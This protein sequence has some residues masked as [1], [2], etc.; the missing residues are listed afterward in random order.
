MADSATGGQSSQAL[1][2]SAAQHGQ[3]LVCCR[4]VVGLSRRATGA[5]FDVRVPS[6]KL[7][8]LAPPAVFLPTEIPQLRVRGAVPHKIPTDKTAQSGIRRYGH[9]EWP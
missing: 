6:R 5:G 9:L 7:P 8:E 2:K 4:R 3:A 1:P